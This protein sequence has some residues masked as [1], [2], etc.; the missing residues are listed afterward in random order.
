MML[1]SPLS[2]NTL[3]H[4]ANKVENLE[5]ILKEDFYPNYCLENLG[6]ITGGN[7]RIAIPMVCFCDIPL[8]QIHKHTNTY[9]CYALGLTKE[10][11]KRNGISPVLYTF[12][13]ASSAKN[14]INLWKIFL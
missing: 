3:F 8:S 11:G 7:F 14:I 2:A 5:G 1:Y 4:F 9:G 6:S 10:W 12:K 13:E